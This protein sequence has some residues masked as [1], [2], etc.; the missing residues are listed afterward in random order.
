LKAKD[1][2]NLS[3]KIGGATLTMEARTHSLQHLNDTLREEGRAVDLLENLKAKDVQFYV[4]HQQA[5]GVGDRTLQNRMSH[6]RSALEAIGREQL[7][8]SEH[9]SSKTLGIDGA[10]RAG[11]HRAVTAEEYGRALEAAK[12]RNEGFAACLQLQRELG[13]R[14][15]EAIQSVASLKSW[16]RAIERGDS[17][18]ITHG[19]KGGRVRDTSPVNRERALDAVKAAIEASKSNGGRLIASKSLE[20]AARAY[21]RFCADVGLKG[22]LSSHALRY[23]FTQ[24]RMAQNLE[25]TAGD[26]AEALALTSLEL[27]HGDGRGTYVEQVYLR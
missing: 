6:L 26:R 27:G 18:R 23:S 20:G 21:Q 2:N 22:E 24:E 14:Q 1:L 19:T 25:Y 11:T 4:D 8:K 13:L 10:S 5:A 7:A 15:R 16:E 3:S 17:V 9:L 12:E